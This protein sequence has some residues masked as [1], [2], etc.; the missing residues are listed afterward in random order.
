MLSPA[1]VNELEEEYVSKSFSDN[2]VAPG[3]PQCIL[4]EN[5][6]KKFFGNEVFPVLVSSGTAAIHLSLLALGVNK[7]DIVLVQSFTFAASVN[8]VLYVGAKPVLI[9]SE[10][11][12]WNMCPEQLEKAILSYT[13]KGKLPKA[14]ITVDLY[15]MPCNYTQIIEISKKY[16]IPVIEDSAEALG[17]SHQNQLCGTFGDY[18]IVSFNGNKIITMSSGGAVLCKTKERAEYIRFLANQAK[19]ESSYYQHSQLGFNYAQSNM[20][21]AMGRAQLTRLP[22]FIE[23]RRAINAFY[24]SL[25][26]SYDYIEVISEPTVAYISNYWLTCILIHPNEHG[27][28]NKDVKEYLFSMGIESRYLWKPMHL[29]PLYEKAEYFGANLED[30]LFENGLCLPSSPVLTNEDLRYIENTIKKYFKS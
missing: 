19:D 22:N 12:T 27:K 1:C 25:F 5:E 6:L 10:L 24:K 2:W 18:G 11:N 3:G 28:S 13:N 26:K 30:S 9:G 8:P 15:G 29:Q 14:I 20:L 23:R 21:A 4:F 7:G 17:S 16:N